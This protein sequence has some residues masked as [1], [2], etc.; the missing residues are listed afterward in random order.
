M[1]I[2][3]ILKTNQVNFKHMTTT[4]QYGATVQFVVLIIFC[5]FSGLTH[6]KRNVVR[7][8]FMLVFNNALSTKHQLRKKQKLRV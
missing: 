6:R 7:K 4:Q 2:R 8:L 1:W 5:P 3:T